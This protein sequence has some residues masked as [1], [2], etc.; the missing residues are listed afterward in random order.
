[1]SG[2]VGATL[3]LRFSIADPDGVLYDP[4]PG[5]GFIYMRPPGRAI[6]E[7]DEYPLEASGA[8]SNPSIGIYVLALDTDVSQ[9]GRWRWRVQAEQSGRVDVGEGAFD[10]EFS[11]VYSGGS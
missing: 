8:V 6:D 3:T 2:L 9:G 1:M 11:R 5:T 10:L 7:P 4:D